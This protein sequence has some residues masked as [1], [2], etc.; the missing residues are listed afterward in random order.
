MSLRTRLAAHC[1]VKVARG[2]G[3]AGADRGKAVSGVVI[4]AVEPETVSEIT[5]PAASWLKVRV[6]LSTMLYYS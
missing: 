4:E 3:C 1:I 6:S 2:K 5:L